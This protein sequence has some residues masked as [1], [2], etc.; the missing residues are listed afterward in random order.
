[1]TRTAR[2]RPGIPRKGDSRGGHAAL[3]LVIVVLIQVL[4]VNAASASEP[5]YI[6]EAV[7]NMAIRSTRDRGASPV[8]YFEANDIVRILEVE[9]EWLYVRKSSGGETEGYVLR[10][11]VNVTKQLDPDALPYG[12]VPSRHAARVIYDAPLY[13]GPSTGSSTLMNLPEGSRVAIISIDNGWAKVLYFRQYGY[14]YMSHLKELEPVMPDA[15]AAKP[16]QLIAAFATAYE[17]KEDQLNIGRMNNIE[18]VCG[19]MRGQVMLPGE[20]I[21]FNKWVGPYSGARG[22]MEAPILFDGKTMPGYGGGTC[23]V[24]TTLYNALLPLRGITVL[25]RRAHGPSGAVYVPHGVDAAVGSA[26]I[27][28]RFRNDYSFPIMF[29]TYAGRGM[30]FIGIYKAW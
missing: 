3:A 7:T 26:A 13:D 25:L 19:Y 1:M 30:L 10:H 16:G 22:Y 21:S 4:C 27:D 5:V 14:V 24:S 8:G 2:T 11:L 15:L 9:P 6:G 28:L 20:E 12:A 29:E 18:V 23:Q 17:T